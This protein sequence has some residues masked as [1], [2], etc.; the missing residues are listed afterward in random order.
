MD[1]PGQ[2][3]RR[4]FSRAR[5]VIGLIAMVVGGLM[6]VDGL[7]GWG[8]RMHVPI[9]PWLLIVLGVARLADQSD[10]HQECPK[11]RRLAAW[12]VF[13]GAWGLLNEYRIFGAH[14]RQSWPLLL[15]GAGVLVVWQALEAPQNSR[16]LNHD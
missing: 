3:E 2:V 9:W 15:I 1:M 6:L 8:V 16:R 11:S 13:M 7:D 10:D 12:L 5:V 4:Q 14:P